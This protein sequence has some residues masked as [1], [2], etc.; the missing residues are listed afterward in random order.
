[1]SCVERHD[2]V[3]FTFREEGAAFICVRCREQIGTTNTGVILDRK[4]V[5]ASVDLA[6]RMRERYEA[7]KKEQEA[8]DGQ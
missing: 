2:L 4:T 6:L 3:H 8:K 1:M 7:K 5:E